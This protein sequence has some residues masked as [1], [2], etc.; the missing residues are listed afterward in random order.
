MLFNTMRINKR[1]NHNSSFIIFFILVSA[2][3]LPFLIW[4][5]Y[6]Q[7]RSQSKAATLNYTMPD[8]DPQTGE[9]YDLWMS[10]E[11]KLVT[12]TSPGPLYSAQTKIVLGGPR[13][14]N[15]FQLYGKK[16]NSEAPYAPDEFHFIF[17]DEVLN[18]FT[19]TT[20][21]L[22]NNCIDLY[23]S[24]PVR[25]EFYIA[26]ICY[27]NQEVVPNQQ[28]RIYS[29][30]GNPWI[31]YTYQGSKPTMVQFF[32]TA[33]NKYL[34][35]PLGYENGPLMTRVNALSFDTTTATTSNF[36]NVTYFFQGLTGGL[37]NSQYGELCGSPTLP[38]KY[39]KFTIGALLKPEGGSHY[40]VTRGYGCNFEL[41]LP[42]LQPFNL[43]LF[44]DGGIPLPYPTSTPT[45][46]NTPTP[47]KTPTPTPKPSIIPIVTNCKNQRDR[48][49]CST[50]LPCPPKKQCIDRVC[51]QGVCINGSCTPNTQ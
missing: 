33:F 20:N 18:R 17:R 3:I 49:R 5:S 27:K 6:Q 1:K 40:A 45:I 21:L 11:V 2:I 10:T 7:T 13:F 4:A 39:I 37:S 46:H 43:S 29:A 47:S 30:S 16:Q 14:N 15:T 22:S 25:K 28:G 32:S 38:Q 9:F 34:S 26:T 42:R 41:D 48:T 23:S 24:L 35:K 50:C 31:Q 12:N 51:P 19:V 8:V 44:M 36:K